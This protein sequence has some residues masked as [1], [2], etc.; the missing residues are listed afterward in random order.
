MGDA[1]WEHR[2]GCRFKGFWLFRRMTVV[3][4]ADGGL[5]IHSPNALTLALE[6]ELRELGPVRYVVAPSLYHHAHLEAYGEAFP[7]AALCAPA[8]LAVKRAG[9][10]IDVIL[11][12]DAELPWTEEIATQPVG[13]MPELQEHAFFHRAS[14]TLI[15]ADLLFR[16]GSDDPWLTRMLGRVDGTYQRVAVSRDAR[17]RHLED[18]A[19]FAASAAAICAW[20]VEHLLMAHARRLETIAPDALSRAL[21][22]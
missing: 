9:L 14:A 22:I 8:D 18:P 7:D 2:G 6:G 1:I 11:D 4:L 15:V 21:G 10:E 20:P 13:G 19:A 5:W 12:E 3:Q 16:F 17:R